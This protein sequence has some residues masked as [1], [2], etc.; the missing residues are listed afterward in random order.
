MRLVAGRP[1]R[2]ND[3]SGIMKPTVAVLAAGIV[4]ATAQ[5]A[6]AHEAYISSGGALL[7]GPAPDYPPV[8]DVSAGEPVQVFGCIDGYSWCD[9]SFRG[10]RG[11]FDGR[12]LAYPY[13]GIR[14]PLSGFGG[15]VGVPVEGFSVEDYWD[16]F[17]RDR[18][19]YRDR[20][21]WAL[22]DQGPGLDRVHGPVHGT[23]DR[24]P[25]L[26]PTPQL[27]PRPSKDSDRAEAQP[28]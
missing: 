4:F 15:Q 22:R 20:A 3:K 25:H 28:R 8:A 19:F 10:Y 27:Q 18:P 13:Q 11:W 24:G 1:D 16:R 2:N 5:G 6:Q 12:Q 23:A 17:Y 14:V 7:A 9:V 26:P 21:R